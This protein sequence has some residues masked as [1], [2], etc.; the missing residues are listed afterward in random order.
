MP[1][2]FLNDP[3]QLLLSALFAVAAIA[4]LRVA[5]LTHGSRTSIAWAFLSLGFALRLVSLQLAEF[6]P[7]FELLTALS[8]VLGAAIMMTAASRL[9][10]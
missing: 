5:L 1:S 2:W 6:A 7:T 3:Q 4:A 9:R 8:F 10:R